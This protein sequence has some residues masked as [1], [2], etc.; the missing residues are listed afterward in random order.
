MALP[1]LSSALG[2]ISTGPVGSI[3]AGIGGSLFGG[4]DGPGFTETYNHSRKLAHATNKQAARG[5]LEGKLK[6]AAYYGPRTGIHPLAAIG[7]PTGSGPVVYNKQERI[8]SDLGQNI[9][10]AVQSSTR[11]LREK[12]MHELA[13]ERAKLE[14][15][16]LRS[17]LTNIRNSPGNPPVAVDPKIDTRPTERAFH[18]KGDKSTVYGANANPL[19]ASDRIH[20]RTGHIVRGLSKQAKDLLEDDPEAYVQTVLH[21]RWIPS[22][23]KAFSKDTWDSYKWLFKKIAKDHLKKNKKKYQYRM[24]NPSVFDPKNW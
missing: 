22:V 16:L 20:T 24:K 2:G 10:R 6:A 8:G 3:L 19:P 18:E 7:V 13:M 17:Q 15:D 21:D 14:N 23:R 5:A 1:G 11:N 12:Q 4:D 9:S